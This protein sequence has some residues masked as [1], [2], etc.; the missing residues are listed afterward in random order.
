ML[1]HLTAF[2]FSIAFIM[3]ISSCTAEEKAPEAKL[4]WTED[5]ANAI[6]L[7]KEKNKPVFALFTGSDWCGWCIKLDK[8]V[9]SKKDFADYANEN[10]ILFKADYPRAIAQSDTVK[11]QNQKLAKQF[12]VR[13]YPTVLILD[14]DSKVIGK[15]G[16]KP[17]GPKPYIENLKEM[18]PAK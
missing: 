11:D 16:Y 10:F 6:L 14:K 4:N 9:F 8:E 7:A 1:K 12:G 2:A 17:G 18:L 13:G 3:C 15:T 5:F